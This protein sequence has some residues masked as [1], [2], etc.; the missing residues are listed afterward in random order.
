MIG[1]L[2]Q[3]KKFIDT[4][5]LAGRRR[6]RAYSRFISWQVSQLISRGEKTVSF[7][8]ETKLAVNKGMKGA[9]G[10]IYTGL[11]DFVDMGFLLHFLR[12]EDLFYDIG[13]N[14]GTYSV[15]ASG[16]AGARS[17]AFEPIPITF[18]SLKK[19]IEINHLDDLV[20]A[21]NIGIGSNKS[22]LYFTAAY[23]ALN[24]VVTTPDEGA[25]CIEVAV[26]NVDNIINGENIPILVKIDVEGFETEV[27]NGMSH[28]LQFEQ[29]KAIIIELNGSGRRYGFDEELIDKLLQEKNFVPCNYNPFTRELSRRETRSLLNTIYV[30]DL[31][32][33]RSRVKTAK[34][35]KVFS[36]E[37]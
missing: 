16:C 12:N 17:Y 5:P 3:I 9:T 10:N 4:H 20:Y 26:D 2:R 21:R 24:H 6:I 7:I 23:D 18:N 8:G 27:L 35:I 34:K 14:V 15:L 30:R 31:E 37:F 33:V 25:Q 13:A 11:H 28:C 1:K 32:F 19:N 36:E 29:L 22:Y